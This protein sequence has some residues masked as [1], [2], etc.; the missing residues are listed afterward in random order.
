MIRK[1]H[2]KSEDDV[3]IEQRCTD[4]IIDRDAF[5]LLFVNMSFDDEALEALQ[6][7]AEL[8]LTVL[9]HD[10]NL[11]AIHCG[12]TVICI[13]LVASRKYIVNVTLSQCI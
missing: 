13:S 10:T 4:F 1:I 8:Y 12:R 5:N 11:A 6:I 2:K 3:R 7:V 9:F